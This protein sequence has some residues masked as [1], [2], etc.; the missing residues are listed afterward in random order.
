MSSEVQDV[1]LNDHLKK[2]VNVVFFKG[3]EIEGDLVG[4]DA[5]TLVIER[6][7]GTNDTVLVFKNA[8]QY[9]EEAIADLGVVG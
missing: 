2:K 6:S 5:E 1:W 7:T 9:V 4:F 3:Q 8:V